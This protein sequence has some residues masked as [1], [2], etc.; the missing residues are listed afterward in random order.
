[1]VT[2]IGGGASEYL[3]WSYNS[4]ETY[5]LQGAAVLDVWPLARFRPLQTTPE[6]RPLPARRVLVPTLLPPASEAPAPGAAQAESR[7]DP[8]LVA[9]AI[10]MTLALGIV[11]GCGLRRSPKD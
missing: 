11:I 10:L 2:T 9:I 4:H 1:M 6:P 3:D 5:R 7:T 8:W